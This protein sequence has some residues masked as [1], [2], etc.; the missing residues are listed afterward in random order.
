[1]RKKI[2][3]LLFTLSVLFSGC[4]SPSQKPTGLTQ[5]QPSQNINPVIARVD[6]VEIKKNDL[7]DI[8]LAGRGRAVLEELTLLQVVRNHAAKRNLAA[9]P[10]IIASELDIILEDMA[11]GKNKKEQLDL[12]Q[13]MLQ[14]RGM[15]RGEF[16]LIVERQA[17]LRRMVDANPPITEEM[18]RMEFD[19]LHGP[20]VQVRRLV[21]SSRRR[22]EDAQNK[23]A[24]GYD[25]VQLIR[26]MSEDEATLPDEGLLPPFSVHDEEIPA[27]IRT[28]AFPLEREGQLSEIITYNDR[29]L[30][31]WCALLRLEKI[32]PP[33]DVSLETI[34]TELTETLK[35]KIIRKEMLNL[36]NR[37][38]QKA[39]INI[40]DP[41]LKKP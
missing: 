25:F 6:G 37:L 34:R 30:R 26:D 14:S 38:K 13:F 2:L 21:A 16:N 22:L 11:P 9:T 7:V 17:L 19:R 24:L 1:M 39:N 4:N 23:L 8:L 40:L 28:A 15:T 3:I 32:I 36:Q 29:E 33:D 27:E 31:Q 12:L 35:Q 5:S 20:K 18:L 10:E 41:M